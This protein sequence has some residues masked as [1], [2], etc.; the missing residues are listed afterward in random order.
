MGNREEIMRK[1][2]LKT[3]TIMAY[4][5]LIVTSS[6]AISISVSNPIT[7][8]KDETANDSNY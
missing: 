3:L 6:F 2:I 7:E 8:Y 5:V 4:T 1:T